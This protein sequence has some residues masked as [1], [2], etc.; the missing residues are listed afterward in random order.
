MKPLSSFVQKIGGV[1][2]KKKGLGVLFLGL[3]LLFLAACGGNDASSGNEGEISNASGSEDDNGEEIT[4]NFVHWINEET[5]NWEDL[6]EVYEEENPGINIESEALVENMSSQD[7]LKQLDL[8]ASAGEKF[9][10][11]MFSNSRDF[12][13]RIESGMVSPIDSLMEEEGIDINEVYN[14]TYPAYQDQYYGLPMKNITNVIMM[15]KNHL[16]EAGLE[17]PTEWTWEEFREYSKQLTTEDRYGSFFWNRLYSLHK[18]QS[19]PENTTLFLEDGS[20]NTDDPVLRDSLQYRYQLEQEDKSAVPIE[21]MLSQQLDYRQQFFTESASMLPIASYMI[22]EWGQFTPDFEIAWAPWPKLAEED[23]AYSV[24]AGDVI[25]ISENS[26]HKQ[27]AYDFIRWLSTEGISQQGVWVP[28]WAEADLTSVLGE[29]V[30]NTSVPEAND[31]ESLENALTSVTPSKIITPPPY[32]AE[33]LTEYQAE[34]E[35]YLLEEQDLDTTMEN[36][37]ERVQ[38][39]VNANQ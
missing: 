20:P 37:K 32:E 36:I 33:A 2:M 19:K 16:D 4:L 18:L 3:M 24:M 26:E 21:D 1:Y 5:A 12:V 25:A 34:M 27:A 29:L 8:L 6:I 17:I 9:D 11:M 39:V 15:N 23:E 35:L 22:T 10:I 28:S 7:Y 13:K 31:L 30:Q 38:Q 14:N